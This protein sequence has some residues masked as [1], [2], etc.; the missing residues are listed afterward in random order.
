[1]TYS[2]KFLL[3]QRTTL[4]IWEQSS[5]DRRYLNQ[6]MSFLTL[7]QNILPSLVAFAMMRHQD[8]TDSRNLTHH[9][10]HS[11]REIKNLRDARLWLTICRSLTL[12]RS[13]LRPHQSSLT[14][15]LSFK[16]SSGKITLAS[17]L[18][19]LRRKVE[20]ILNC[21]LLKINALYS[22]S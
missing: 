18:L 17:N 22:N 8:N 9:L 14:D 11:S 2:F 20:L 3:F 1:M 7:D 19:T 4:S 21:S 10:K 6:P 12:K 16:A 13:F 15:L 5:L